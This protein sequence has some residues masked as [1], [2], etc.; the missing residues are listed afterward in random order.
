MRSFTR[1]HQHWIIGRKTSEL[2]SKIGFDGSI[3]FARAIRINVSTSVRKLPLQ[4]V[5][6]AFGFQFRV[7]LL[8]P[9]HECYVIRAERGID[10]QLP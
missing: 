10:Y 4:N 6:D 3:N 5:P 8:G 7:D 9:V 1:L 2:Q